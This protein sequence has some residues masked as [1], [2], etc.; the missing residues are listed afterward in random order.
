MNIG[1]S[2][3][4]FASGTAQCNKGNDTLTVSLNDQSA[5]HFIENFQFNDLSKEDS[6]KVVSGIVKDS[7]LCK[8][9]SR[10]IDQPMYLCAE[11]TM[12]QVKTY[13]Q[14]VLSAGG[15]KTFLENILGKAGWTCEL[16]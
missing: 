14:F 11:T 5:L 3:S 2:F 16:K 15:I 13:P 12:I 10:I 9:I 4:A 6:Y 1:L 7:P 8:S